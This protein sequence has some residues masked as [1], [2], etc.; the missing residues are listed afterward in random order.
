MSRLRLSREKTMGPVLEWCSFHISV[1]T[2][3]GWAL[4]SLLWDPQDVLRKKSVQS[5]T[6]AFRAREVHD[7][8]ARTAP[9]CFLVSS[10]VSLERGVASQ[11][12]G[13][14]D[15]FMLLR[16]PGINNYPSTTDLDLL[17]RKRR[18]KSHEAEWNLETLRGFCPETHTRCWN[19][20]VPIA[21]QCQ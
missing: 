6:L 20:E 8:E 18:Q 5:C 9:P 1:M 16:K 19:F 21:W 15:L 4:E 14:R 11:N 7:R 13:C 12:P 2:R 10:R 17:K 3:G